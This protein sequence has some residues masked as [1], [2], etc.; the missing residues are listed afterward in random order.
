MQCQL[1]LKDPQYCQRSQENLV[2]KKPQSERKK[3]TRS[4]E[5]ENTQLWDMNDPKEV[6]DD[7]PKKKGGFRELSQKWLDNPDGDPKDVK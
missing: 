4:L 2:Q 5:E 6:L 3:H 1:G 7:I